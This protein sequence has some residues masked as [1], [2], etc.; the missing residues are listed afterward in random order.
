MTTHFDFHYAKFKEAG[1][2][3]S[4]PDGLEVRDFQRWDDIREGF[5]P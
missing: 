2:K 4:N 3:I 5:N 1:Q